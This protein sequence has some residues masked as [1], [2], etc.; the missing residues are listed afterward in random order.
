MIRREG[1]AWVL[2][3]RSTG[4]VLGRHATRADAVRQE[5]AIHAH[6][7]GNPARPG[8]RG[9]LEVSEGEGGAQ[10]LE[11]VVARGEQSESHVLYLVR[12]DPRDRS[13]PMYFGIGLADRDG[14]RVTT[15]W[16]GRLSRAGAVRWSRGAARRPPGAEHALRLLL[17]AAARRMARGVYVVEIP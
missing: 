1:N 14:F 7:R 13:R 16:S 4:R 12:A 15:I 5:M 17:D 10:R 9:T 6:S 3:A 2:R 11:L 8:D